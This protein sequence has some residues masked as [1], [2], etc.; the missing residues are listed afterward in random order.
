M[1]FQKGIRDCPIRKNP[2]ANQPI[3]LARLLLKDDC[4]RVR[5]YV[6]KNAVINKP[7]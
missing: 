7:A 4:G 6:N 5:Q 1:S 2:S 3:T